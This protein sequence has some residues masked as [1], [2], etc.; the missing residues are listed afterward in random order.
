MYH[1]KRCLYIASQAFINIPGI[2]PLTQ[3]AK[4][5]CHFVLCT[6]ESSYFV[7]QM[8]FPVTC[9]LVFSNLI[10]DDLDKS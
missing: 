4:R 1:K 3:T 7:Q 10:A 5:M 2:E 9:L 8:I 6:I